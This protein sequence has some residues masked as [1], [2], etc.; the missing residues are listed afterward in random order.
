MPSPWFSSGPSCRR[1]WPRSWWAVYPALDCAAAMSFGPFRPSRIPPGPPTGSD[2]PTGRRPGVATSCRR[3]PPAYNRGHPGDVIPAD[4]RDRA[5]RRLARRLRGG[6]ALLAWPRSTVVDSLG[7][8][9]RVTTGLVQVSLPGRPA[10]VVVAAALLQRRFRLL[11]GL[12]W[13][14]LAA[15]AIAP[16]Y[17]PCSAASTPDAA[18]GHPLRAGPGCPGRV[19]WPGADRFRG[20]RVSLAADPWLSRAVAPCPRGL[21]LLLVRRGAVLTRQTGCCRW[22]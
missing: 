14:P 11:A 17:L 13:G 5:A 3:P 6:V 4:L 19:P 9:R 2:H 22:S 20:G 7:S 12:A 1:C 18:H 15:S 21:T 16:G 10:A 8:P